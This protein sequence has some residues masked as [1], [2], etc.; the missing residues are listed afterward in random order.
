M[1]LYFVDGHNLIL[2]TEMLSDLL[3]LEGRRASREEA[4]SLVLNWADR[5]GDVRVRLY[6]DG[7][8]FEGGHPGNR[9][10]GPLSVRFTDPPAEADDRI[11]YEASR[12]AGA[13]EKVTVVTGD[14]GIRNR[15]GGLSVRFLDGEQYLR[16][17]TAPPAPPSKEGR[18][19]DDEQAVLGR[20]LRAHASAGDRPGVGG[21]PEG[22]SRRRPAKVPVTKPKEPPVHA[23]PDKEARVE[24]YR[25][26]ADKRTKKTAATK[27]KPRKKR[28]GY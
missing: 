17:L 3:E 12:E 6:Y 27:P 10:E 19:S 28:R 18:F 21:S 2:S 7:Q 23:R 8:Q 5:E 20:E 16:D 11:V 26:R 15:L 9:D 25:K 4:E 22:A 13:G 1:R 14:G 24:A